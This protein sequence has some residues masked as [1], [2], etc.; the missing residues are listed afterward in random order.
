MQRKHRKPN[1]EEDALGC[2]HISASAL[3]FKETIK[4]KEL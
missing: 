1:E 2:V 4:Y 3:T